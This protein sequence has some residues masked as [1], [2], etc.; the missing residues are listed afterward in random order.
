MPPTQAKRKKTADMPDSPPKRVTR[1][2]AAKVTDDVPAK[3]KT[4]RITTAS[5]KAA[6]EKKKAAVPAAKAGVPARITKRK[7]R[8]DDEE[9]KVIEDVEMPAAEEPVLEEQSESKPAKAKGRQKKTVTTESKDVEAA[10]A[11]KTRGRQTKTGA[12]TTGI[13]KPEPPKPRGRAKKVTEVVTTTAKSKEETKEIVSEPARKTTRGRPAVTTTTARVTTTLPKPVSA[14]TKKRVKFDEGNDKE[15]VPV[16]KAGP[17]KSAMKPA[18]L[19]AKPIRKPVV[20]R[21]TTRARKNTQSSTKTLGKTEKTETMPLSPKK[22]NQVAKSDPISEDELAG[23]KTPVRALS[24]SPVKRP[25]SPIKDVGSV[26]KL[27]Y[28]Q[29]SAPSSPAK[30]ASSNVFGSPARRPPPSPFKDALKASPKKL[31]LGDCL[32]QPLLLSSRTP[33]KA[34]LLQESPKRGAF[35]ESTVQPTFLPSK[36]PFKASLLQSPARRPMASPTKTSNL[37]SPDKSRPGM[38]ATNIMGSPSKA[39]STRAPKFSPDTFVSSPF[40]AARSPEQ[41]AKVHIIT[42]EERNV[43]VL[44]NHS[45]PS[46]PMGPEEHEEADELT[47]TPQDP[48]TTI[49]ESMTSDDPLSLQQSTSM[50]GQMDVAENNL[51]QPEAAFPAPAFAIGSSSLRRTSMESQLSEDELASPQ[52]IYEI[53]PLRRHGISAEDFG[54]PAV[55]GGQEQ[56]HSAAFGLPFTPLA[57]QLSSWN[58]TS[59]EKSTRPRQARGMFSLGG[60]KMSP[61]NEQPTPAVLHGSPAKSSFFEDEMAFHNDQDEISFFETD[62]EE[63]TGLAMLKVSQDSQAS[64]E[65]GDENAAP[66]DLNLH[67]VEQEADRTITCIPAKIFTPA[68]VIPHPGEIYTVSKVPLRPSAEDTPLRVPRQRSRSFGGPLATFIQPKVA[69]VNNVVVEQPTTPILAP[70]LSPQT[71]SSSMKLDVETPGRTARKG[72]VP[73]VLKGA[74]VHVDVHTT[75]GADAS[76]IFVDLLTQMGARCVKQWHWNPRASM[77]SSLDGTASPQE[78]SPDVTASK[79]GITHVVYK[80]GGKRTLEKVRSTNGVVHCVGVGWVLE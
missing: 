26:S 14:P 19:N 44:R 73:D 7:T 77:G 34:S 41:Q 1:A 35:P 23:E 63:D 67:G 72:V 51:T 52:R 15:N 53:T 38:M 80:D 43:D 32:G 13:A 33:K 2:R 65:Y 58:T 70:S 5:S 37:G 18:G 24:M 11:P 64:E 6:S 4:T 36:S 17:K 10:E 45:S 31:D 62:A 55:I 39:S 57:N 8:A 76:G 59:P 28:D 21:A 29:T 22:V 78:G 71:P 30:P 9:A 47:P 20:A 75:E 12:T 54:T 50:P 56:A 74:I 46:K 16:E 66:A 49:D 79:I 40:K 27:D 42:D 61:A 68:R 25:M 60:A 3:P 69:Q 48:D